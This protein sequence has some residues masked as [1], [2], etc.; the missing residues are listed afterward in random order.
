MPD[1]VFGLGTAP[2]C[3]VLMLALNVIR[4]AV[5]EIGVCMWLISA[6]PSNRTFLSRCCAA[7][8]II[9]MVVIVVTQVYACA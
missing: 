3:S 6:N 7:V 4:V 9:R 2:E 8:A 5:E 1:M